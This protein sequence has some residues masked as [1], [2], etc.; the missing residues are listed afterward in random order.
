MEPFQMLKQ[1]I[2]TKTGNL[3]LGMKKLE[4]TY[5]ELTTSISKSML[6]LSLSS[7]L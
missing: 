1:W 7:F 5:N 6:H 4:I 3:F 2:L